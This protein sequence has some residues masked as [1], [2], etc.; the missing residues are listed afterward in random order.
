MHKKDLQTLVLLSWTH[1]WAYTCS[2]S[3]W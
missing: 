2:L 1:Y 3:T